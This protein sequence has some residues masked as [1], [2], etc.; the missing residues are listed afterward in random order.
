MAPQELNEKRDQLAQEL[1][2]ID[3]AIEAV[4]DVND[5]RRA[6][7]SPGAIL[8]VTN[9]EADLHGDLYVDEISPEAR[10]LFDQ[11]LA[12]EE[13][14]ILARVGFDKKPNHTAP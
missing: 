1:D 12:V 11:L 3:T 2:A 5:I 10:A 8:S 7:I 4:R 9:P 14:R 6:M 13:Q